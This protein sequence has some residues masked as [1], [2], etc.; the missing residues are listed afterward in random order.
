MGVRRQTEKSFMGAVAAFAK[1]HG[2]TVHHQLESR[3]TEAGIPDLLFTRGPGHAVR[4]VW[5]ELKLGGK[6]PTPAQLTVLDALRHESPHVFVWRPSD[7][8]EIER[9]LGGA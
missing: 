8:S 6:D 5:A 7:W 1:L 2:W 3:G 9:V 4:A